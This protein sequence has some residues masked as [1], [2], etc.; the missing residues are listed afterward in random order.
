M[1]DKTWRDFFEVDVLG[2]I[3]WAPVMALIYL[4]LFFDW[5]AAHCCR[6]RE[7]KEDTTDATEE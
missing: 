1:R 2:A 6:K 7:S 5:I 4:L 3:L